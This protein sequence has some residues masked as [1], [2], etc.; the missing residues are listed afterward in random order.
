ML[1]QKLA[2]NVDLG[3]ILA[4]VDFFSIDTDPLLEVGVAMW[5][6]T[7]T[8]VQDIHQVIASGIGPVSKPVS[9]SIM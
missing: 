5:A 3:F 8:I 9:F 4:L 7:R 6:W 2:V 1:V